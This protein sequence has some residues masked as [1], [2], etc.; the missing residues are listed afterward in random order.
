MTQVH[1]TKCIHGLVKIHSDVFN[2]LFKEEFSLRL[3]LYIYTCMLRRE[4]DLL[5]RNNVQWNCL[6]LVRYMPNSYCHTSVHN[7]FY[8]IRESLILL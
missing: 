7:Y 5:L 3:A 4:H 1:I 2:A 8:Q 6:S